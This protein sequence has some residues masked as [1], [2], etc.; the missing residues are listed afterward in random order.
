LTNAYK[1]CNCC[2]KKVCKLSL[3][4]LLQKHFC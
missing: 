2:S 3:F 1:Q 4:L